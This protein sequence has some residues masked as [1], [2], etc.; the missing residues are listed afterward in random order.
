MTSPS[1][2]STMVTMKVSRGPLTHDVLETR[3]ASLNIS[4]RNEQDVLKRLDLIQQKI[5]LEKLLKKRS[6]DYS[7]DHDEDEEE[8]L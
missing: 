4:I 3:L 5:S 1:E 6:P 7:E 8:N 2:P